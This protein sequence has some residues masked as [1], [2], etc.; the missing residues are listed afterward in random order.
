MYADGDGQ[1]GHWVHDIIL[2]HIDEDQRKVLTDAV[3]PMIDFSR[4]GTS[5]RYRVLMCT[6]I[7]TT[8]ASGRA[9][10]YGGGA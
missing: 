2:V 4:S 7:I 6:Q 9:E 8:L 5:E 1:A 10:V 3:T